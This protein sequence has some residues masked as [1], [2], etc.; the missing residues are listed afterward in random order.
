MD[1][2][3]IKH[4][5]DFINKLETRLNQEGPFAAWDLFQM[6]YHAA[7]TTMSP[8]FNGLKAL[9][10]LPHMAFMDHQLSSAKQVIED[11][12]GRAI[13]ADEVGLGKTIEAGLILK[14]YMLRGLVKKALII[15][16][17]SLVN[18]WAKELNEKF[19][20]PAVT[21]R[22]TYPWDQFD[23]II[24]SMDTAKRSPHRE[25]I[26]EQDYDFLLVDEAH[27]LK[28]HKTKNY[29]FVKSLKKKY[30][31]LL[32]AT[33]VQ[34][35]LVEIFNLVSILKPGHLGDYDSFLKQYGKDRKKLGQDGYLKQLI[36]KVM[37]RNTRQTAT[38]DHIKRNIE[39]VWIDFTDEEHSVYSELENMTETLPAFSKITLLREL[40]SSREACY[41]SLKKMMTEDQTKEQWI[42][43]VTE[44]IEQ[45]PQH[46]KAAKVVELINKTGGEKV[47]VFTEY[48]ATQFY[49]Q[50]YLKENG[51]TSVPYRGGFNKG[52]KDWMKQLFENHAQVLIATE[53]GG[54]G[55]N[56]QFCNHLINYDLPW[57]P[58][59]LEQRIGRI[60]RY[61]QKRDVHIYNVA[62]RDTVEEHIMTL[63]YEKIN[64]FEQVIG[65]LDSILAELDISDIESEI[66]SI[67][68]ESASAGEAKIK[69]N[70]LSS[71][72]KMTHDETMQEE[73]HYGN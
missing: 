46:T 26:L 43:P 73:Q 36:Q 65:N 34:N 39:T 72:I 24:T 1:Q 44:A 70:N 56:L 17:A 47:I 20:I 32:T 55:I 23:V 19:Y 29:A 62:V 52:K 11:M 71:V 41:L 64:L 48:R 67:F 60:H 10:Y 37:I 38:F 14:E 40:C 22:K 61:G 35:R 59:R 53:A 5:K 13:L 68:S 28:N 7:Q 27:K 3:D 66:Q 58:M 42:K 54:E 69:L 57:N 51:I 21:F 50:W 33:P 30:C 25:Q 16:P 12:N 45:L 18:Q 31:L 6:N 8:S 4:D 2:I 63:L 49:L 9:E 15:V